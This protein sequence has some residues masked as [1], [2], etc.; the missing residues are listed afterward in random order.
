MGSVR[1]SAI[2]YFRGVPKNF[3]DFGLVAS[4]NYPIFQPTRPLLN[5][6]FF[7]RSISNFISVYR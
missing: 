3:N 1:T 4:G 6:P 7:N 5:T 2:F